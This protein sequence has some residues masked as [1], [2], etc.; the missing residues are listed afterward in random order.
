MFHQKHNK[1]GNQ[2]I[3]TTLNTPSTALTTPDQIN[4]NY[5]FI[6]MEP[7]YPDI[8]KKKFKTI[9]LKDLIKSKVKHGKIIKTTNYEHTNGD[10][11]N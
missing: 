7:N 4:T 2:Q 6:K 10:K 1:S 5:L 8:N 11:N 3:Q 9:F